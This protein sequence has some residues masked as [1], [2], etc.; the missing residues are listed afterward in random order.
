MACAR[1]TSRFTN[2]ALGLDF[3][4]T[5]SGIFRHFRDTFG[6]GNCENVLYLWYQSKYFQAQPIIDDPFDIAEL[7]VE[8]H[9]DH[10]SER[11]AAQRGF[12][13]LH[14]APDQPFREKTLVK[15]IFPAEKRNEVLNEVDFYGVNDLS[16]FPS[17]DGIAA[18]WAWFYRIST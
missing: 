12:F 2:A 3:K 5:N 11:I 7:F 10:Q 13:T 14:K 16:L 1:T 18:Y 17:L 6:K 4:P 8:V 15:F 9:T